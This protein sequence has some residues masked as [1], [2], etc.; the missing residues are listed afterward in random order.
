MVS[1][2]CCVSFRGAAEGFGP[3]RACTHSFQTISHA[4]HYRTLSSVPCSLQQVP[5][6][7]CCVQRRVCAC[8]SQT[9]GFSAPA[10]P[11]I[12]RAPL[13]LQSLDCSSRG[14]GCA[15]L[16]SPLG[17]VAFLTCI[18]VLNYRNRKTILYLYCL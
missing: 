9:P 3:V 17:M 18:P 12:T 4:G 2:Q 10:S 1:L 14:R 16:V 11:L 7:C 15:S 5:V 8:Q 13:C 6:G